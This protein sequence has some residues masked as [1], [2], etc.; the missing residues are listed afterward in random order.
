MADRTYI[1]LSRAWYADSALKGRDF[2]DEI[3]LLHPDSAEVMVRW[4]GNIDKLERAPR[5]ESFMDSWDHLAEIAP[6]LA[7]LHGQELTADQFETFLPAWGY[8]DATPTEAP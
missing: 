2:T 1:R 8:E 4:Y 5:V 6:M 7:Q 3:L